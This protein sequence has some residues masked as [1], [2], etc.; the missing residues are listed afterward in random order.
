MRDHT[1]PAASAADALTAVSRLLA[2]ATEQPEPR[3]VHETLVREA[4]R[5]L[6]ADGAALVTVA[7][8]GRLLAATAPAPEL[9]PAA[10][11][12]LRG[13]LTRR[14]RIVPLPEARTNDLAPLLPRGPMMVLP[15][16]A[17][18]LLVLAGEGLDS[19]IGDRAALAGAFA[20]AAAAA[21]AQVRLAAEHTREMARHAA[22]A[23]AA[24]NLHESLE[25]PV[26]LSRLCREAAEIMDADIA[27][28][29]RETDRGGAKAEAT[30]GCPPEFTGYV[31]A[32]GEGLAGKV[33]QSGRP[34]RTNEYTR[35][36]DRSDASPFRAFRAALG[37]P[38]DWG[39]GVRGALS[40]G[41]RMP[42]AVG[43]DDLRVLETFAELAAV[44]CQNASVHAGLALAA[45]TDGLTGC[46]NH[47]ALHETLGREIERC[48]RTGAPLS[49]VLVDLD[50]F[51]RVND[52]Q[53]HLVGDE[54]LARAGEALRSTTRAYDLAAR[55]GGD[56]FAL[57]LPDADQASACAVAARAVAAVAA[58]GAGGATAGVAQ[59]EPGAAP[60]DLISA[61][62]DALLGAK[63]AGARGTVAAATG[64]VPAP[65]APPRPAPPKPAAA[66][67]T[68][69]PQADRDGRRSGPPTGVELVTTAARA[70]GELTQIGFTV[71][72][73]MLKRA[74]D[75]LPRRS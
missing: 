13:T 60:T 64:I 50:H 44:A 11:A 52:E 21:L 16:G 33:I 65:P 12:L 22:L 67:P 25:L 66:E 59:W 57:V 69:A 55:Y 37:V 8:S 30:F 6:E 34:M 54:I 41:Y 4:S 58:L 31:L 36:A 9:T 23:R 46:L 26:V 19:V 5:L 38:F 63:R 49:L 17:E 70:A 62:D 74:A 20:P 28:V 3:V 71:G 32:P 7:G 47:A 43:A 39:G 72:R 61:A 10:L 56:E 15:V 27:V 45:R 53:G 42:H 18:E 68:P 1:A 14:T 73:Q 48:A 75:R 35:I 51:K 2:L 40:L 24:K 29:Y